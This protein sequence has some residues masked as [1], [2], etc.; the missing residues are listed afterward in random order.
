MG[1]RPEI[2]DLQLFLR[3]ALPCADTLVKRGWVARDVVDVELEHAALT[4]EKPETDARDVFPVAYA[5]CSLTARRMGKPSIDAEVIRTY[6]WGQHDEAIEERHK[7]MGD[8]DEEECRVLMGKVV[9]TSPVTVRTPD[10]E[11]ECR[12]PYN[13]DLSVGDHAVIHYSRVV[14]RLSKEQAREFLEKGKGKPA[15]KAGEAPAKRAGKPA[16][17]AGRPPK[18]EALGTLLAVLTACVSGIAVFANKIFVTGMDPA[19]FTAARAMIIGLIFLLLSFAAGSF[20]PDRRRIPW[21]WLFLVGVVGGGLAF[22]MFFSG[23]Q[24]TTSGRAAFL[25]KTLPLWVAALAAGFL[26]ERIGR[27]QCLAM[28]FMFGGT[29]LIVGAGI[30]PADLWANPALGDMLV[31]AATA[32][33]AVENVAARKLLREGESNFLVSFGRMFFGSLFLL[34]VLGLTGRAGA[35]LSLTAVQ[36]TSLLVSTGLLFF[37]VL[38][39]YWSLRHINV[40]KAATVLLLAPVITLLLGWHYLQEPV[41]LLQIGGSAAILAG[42]FLISKVKSEFHTGV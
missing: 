28:A 34:G 5:R 13:I 3:Y 23:L 26:K 9:N 24:L 10:G 40:S 15:A 6:F 25:H 30:R 37:Y 1:E 33:W 38:F 11:K 31:I 17:K 41:T 8:F 2:K 36:A 16:K 39:Y 4:G 7:E 14:E 19:L 20:R 18:R 42:A 21:L 22:L 29:L 12:N 32:L 35:L 27:K